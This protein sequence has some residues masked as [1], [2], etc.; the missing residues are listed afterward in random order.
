MDDPKD[1]Y[2]AVE[3]FT[4]EEFN[5]KVNTLIEKGWQACGGASVAIN[6]DG[7]RTYVQALEKTRR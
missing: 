7:K 3:A 5:L 6:E 2:F 1:Q 4:L